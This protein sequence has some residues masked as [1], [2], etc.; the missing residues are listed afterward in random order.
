MTALDESADTAERNDVVEPHVLAAA[1][2]ALLPGG[3]YELAEALCQRVEVEQLHAN[4]RRLQRIRANVDQRIGEAHMHA[5]VGWES[6]VGG[7]GER[8]GIRIEEQ[9]P[10][11]SHAADDVTV[12]DRRVQE[13][14]EVLFVLERR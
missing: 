4:R 13:H 6:D 14:D 10:V 7:E 8:S 2:R 5:G 12:D 1:H 11:D 3:S 9:I